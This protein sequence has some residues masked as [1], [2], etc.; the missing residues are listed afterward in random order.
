YAHTM[1]TDQTP[2][3][4]RQDV[5]RAKALLE[6]LAGQPVVGYRAPTFSITER[7]RWAADV[8]AEEGYRYDSSIFPV[9]HDRYGIPTAPRFLHTLAGRN[10]AALVEFP[11]T[12][13]RVLGTNLPVAGGGYLRLLPVW[14]VGAALRRVNRA[15]HPAVIY[16]HPWE[17][18]PEQPRLPV[19]GLR[20]FRHYVGLART[21]A[22]L[23]RLLGALAFT[24][25]GA[26]VARW[27][28]ERAGSDAMSSPTAGGT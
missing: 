19:R 9:R 2:E 25:A 12:T 26:V 18:D 4:F 22:K 6:D 14:L 16:F 17:L 13:L 3:A 27:Q 8:L 20:R 21:A 10:G 1:I 5:R 23:R 24:S 11:P 7:T 28:A 15:G